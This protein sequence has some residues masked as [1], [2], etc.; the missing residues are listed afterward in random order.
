[1]NEKRFGPIR[2]IPGLN[3]GRYPYRNSLYIEGLE[4]LIDPASNRETLNQLRD[5]CVV[6]QVWLTHF[7]EDHIMHLDIFDDVPLKVSEE[8]APFLASL[9]VYLDS[10]W[11]ELNDEQ[12][13]WWT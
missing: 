3:R 10:A 13:L 7:H 12:K 4:I 11:Y 8:D 2:F 5:E 6:D 1:V 9:E